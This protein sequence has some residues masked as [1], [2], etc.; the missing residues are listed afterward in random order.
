MPESAPLSN[1]GERDTRK[2]FIADVVIPSYDVNEHDKALRVTLGGDDV[3]FLA[4]GDRK[5]NGNDITFSDSDGIGVDLEL[6]IA[7]LNAVRVQV[8]KPR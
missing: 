5:E 8:V 7:A 3:L 4:I 2:A 1:Q 6:L